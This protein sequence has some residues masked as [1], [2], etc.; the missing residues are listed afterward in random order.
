MEMLLKDNFKINK[1]F[2]DFIHFLSHEQWPDIMIFD[3]LYLANYS[4]LT[5]FLY[6]YPY[7]FL[8]MG[9][10]HVPFYGVGNDLYFIM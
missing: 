7:P 4:L 6:I 5:Y 3:V 8:D 10:V 2:V 9:A 1:H